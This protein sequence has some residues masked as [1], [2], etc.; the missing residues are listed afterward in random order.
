MYSY[1]NPN[2]LGSRVGDCVVRAVS[3][4]L[5][6]T[7]EGAYI[8]LAIQG[9]IMGDLLSSNAVWGTYLKNNGFIRDVVSAD[10]PDCYTVADFAEEHNSGVYVL[11][12]GSHAICVEDGVVFDSWDSSSE[13]PIYFYYKERK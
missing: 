6:V 4:A 9:Y 12:T 11:G 8:G 3:K 10:C 1:F 2:P 5:N 13:R 7:W